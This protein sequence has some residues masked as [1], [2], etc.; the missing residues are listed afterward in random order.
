MT[1]LE[2]NESEASAI[3]ALAGE[4]AG[5]YVST[6]DPEFLDNAAVYAHEL[7]RRVRA[8][9]NDFRLK[10]PRSALLLITGYPIDDG[11]IGDTLAHWKL[12]TERPPTLEEEIALVL[13][14]SLLGDCIGWATQQDGHIVHD[15]LPIRGL[16][17]EQLGSGSEELLWW[18]TEDAFHPFRGDYLGMLC[19]RNPDAVPTTFASIDG[20]S[21][22]SGH[23]QLLFE[24]HYTIRPDES[25]LPK[26]ISDAARIDGELAGSYGRIEEMRSAP[27][28]IAVLHGDAQAPYVRIDP[29]FMDPVSEPEARAAL[30]A[31]IAAI[32][33]SLHD[34]TLGSGD[35]CFIDNFQGVHGRKPFTAR[36]DGKDRWLKRINIVRDLRKSRAARRG[37]SCRVIVT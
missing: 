14:G 15:I 5:S 9:L 20:I 26:N 13:M 6:D 34:V 31:L 12:R 19:L 33:G 2:L 11:K 3:K 18:H 29:Y 8:C 22:E 28:K 23:R 10:E 36:Y 17:H 35:F 32:E 1:I 27:D 16:E 37:A 30:A 4:L 25:H 24:P 7:P 21:L